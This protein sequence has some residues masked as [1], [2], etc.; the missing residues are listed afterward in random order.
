MTVL[1]TYVPSRTT[2]HTGSLTRMTDVSA[3]DSKIKICNVGQLAAWR[4]IYCHPAD[5]EAVVVVIFTGLFDGYEDVGWRKV[6]VG[7]ALGEEVMGSSV[8]EKVGTAVGT[9]VGKDV[10]EEVVLDES[11]VDEGIAKVCDSVL[12]PV[13][14]EASNICCCELPTTIRHLA[15][16]RSGTSFAVTKEYVAASPGTVSRIE[17]STLHGDRIFRSSHFVYVNPSQSLLTPSPPG[18][19]AFGETNSMLS[20]SSLVP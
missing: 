16:S 17:I 14:K 2:I 20:M 1:S 6:S 8:G 3:E 4:I 19:C 13:G 18:L 10:G 15:G 12:L 9:G 7:S 5:A 11:E